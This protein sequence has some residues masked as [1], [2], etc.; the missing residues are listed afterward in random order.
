MASAMNDSDVP[1]MLNNPAGY[2]TAENAHE[3]LPHFGCHKCGLHGTLGTFVEPNN[4]GTGIICRECRFKHPLGYRGVQ[5]LRRAEK[6]KRS[7]DIAA[8]IKV[9]G[10]YC[11]GCG[12]D[13]DVLRD[14]GI[15]RHVHHTRPFADHG[16][17]YA[18]IPMCA[19]CHE[20]IS[21]AQRH[22]K[23]TINPEKS[24]D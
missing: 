11:Y 16:E 10:D 24:D 13:F 12:T 5:W 15:G 19:L 7:N 17:A 3:L 6:P 23:K 20:L 21:A 18:K 22:M 4:N 2:L 1:K 9:C 8:V 14:R